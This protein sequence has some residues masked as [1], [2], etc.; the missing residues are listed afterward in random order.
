GHVL[1]QEVARTRGPVR[2]AGLRSLDDEVAVELVL[3]RAAGRRHSRRPDDRRQDQRDGN[4]EW[5]VESPA[6]A[7]PASHRP[8]DSWHGRASFDMAGSPRAWVGAVRSASLRRPPE[9]SATLAHPFSPALPNVPRL[10]RTVRRWLPTS[11]C[12]SSYL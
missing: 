10:W 11:N 8:N 1:D 3:V 12:R 2:I 6:L 5:A 7:A 4:G 9:P